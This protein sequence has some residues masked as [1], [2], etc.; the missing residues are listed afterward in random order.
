MCRISGI[1]NQ[2]ISVQQLKRSVSLM[3]DAQQRGGP[4]DDGIFVDES[5]GL[6]LGHR[7]LSIIDLSAGGHQPMSDILNNTHITFNGEIYN[8]RELRTELHKLGAGFLTKTD[9]EVILQAYNYWGTASFAK[10]K[11]I[12]AFGLFDKGKQM[13]YLVRDSKGIKPLYYSSS[14]NTLTFASEVRAFRAAEMM[15]EDDANWR[16]RFLAFGNIPEPFTTL[17]NVYSLPKSNY[18]SWDHQTATYNISKYQAS[19]VSTQITNGN[20]AKKKIRTSFEQAVT[21]QLIADAPIGVFLSGGIDSSLITL[22]ANQ[23]KHASLNTVS[24]HFNERSYDESRYQSVVKDKIE[25][26]KFSHLITQ[27][28]FDRASPS[29]IAAMDMPTTDGINTWFISNFAQQDGLKAVLSGIGADELFGGYPSFQRIKYVNRLRKLPITTL[30]LLAKLDNRFKRATYLKYNHYLADYLFLRGIFSIEEIADLLETE[31]EQVASILFGDIPNKDLG[32]YN[33]LHAS[34]L[35]TNLYMQN[36]LL[37]D[38][39]V[40]GMSNALEIRVPFLD[41]DFC[42]IVD[43]IAAEVRFGNRP[44]QLLIDSFADLLPESIWN[45]PKMGFTFPLQQWLK[46]SVVVSKETYHNRFASNTIDL[47]LKDQTHWSK[48]FALYQVQN[49]A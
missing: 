12:F 40:M 18:L 1:I 8:Y 3:C 21:S 22:L 36:Q 38:T 35:E 24:I 6:A 4:D 23:Q 31:I 48:A 26:Q 10:L 34:W 9:T 29:V 46:Q 28:E 27:A 19:F 43:S 13:T 20:E 25:G 42:N 41:Q 32:P 16:I 33:K 2:N 5:I 7:R 39:D 15:F 30:S 45:R 49:H 47:F 44:K 11:G 37:R 17:K 14:K